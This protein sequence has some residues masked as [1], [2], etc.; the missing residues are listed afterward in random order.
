MSNYAEMY[1]ENREEQS[2]N[3]VVD[4]DDFL[5]NWLDSEISSMY[6]KE[7]EGVIYEY[8]IERAFTLHSKRMGTPCPETL[9]SQLVYCIIEDYITS[10]HSK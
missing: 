6:S 10:I 5:R 9:V 7:L 1:M 3:G 2:G 4:E 8:G